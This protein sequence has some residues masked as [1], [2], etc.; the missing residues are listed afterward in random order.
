VRRGCG[1]SASA[2]TW[3]RRACGHWAG[4]R[5]LRQPPAPPKLCG[6]AA[7]DLATAGERRVVQL[8]GA[9]DPA[10]GAGEEDLFGGDQV[11][12]GEWL[13]EEREARLGGDAKH[14]ASRRPR[15]DAAVKRRCSQRAAADREQVRPAGLEDFLAIEEEGAGTVGRALDRRTVDELVG[16]ETT[17][18]REAAQ[19]DARLREND[20]RVD[21]SSSHLELERVWPRSDR[22]SQ[23]AERR[24][25][26]GAGRLRAEVRGRFGLIERPDAGRQP[27]EVVALGDRLAATHQQRVEDP[28]AGIGFVVRRH[29]GYFGHPS[30]RALLIDNHD[31]FTFNLFQLLAEVGGAEP[32]VVRNDE[33]SWAELAELD[34]DAVVISPGPGRPERRGDF[35]VC[36]EAIRRCE[37]P[38]L[39]VCL[40][41]QGIGF[42]EGG[43][44]E[45]APEPLHGRVAAIEHDDSPL[46]AGIPSPFP[47]TRYHSLALARP[48][49]AELAE[50]AS[51][52]GVPMAVAHRHRPQWGVQFHP[53]SVATPHGR[54]LLANFRDLAAASPRSS[55][56]A[57]RQSCGSLGASETTKEPHDAKRPSSGSFVVLE[58]TK[59]PR[60]DGRGAADRPELE[61]RLAV[62]RVDLLPDAEAFF[63]DLYGDRPHAFWLDSAGAG[64]AS[65]FSFMGDAS[66][67]LGAVVTYDV[68][69][70]HVTVR[71]PVSAGAV[72]P[73]SLQGNEALP[74]SF[75]E[76]VEVRDESI[77]EFVD[78]ELQ[79]LRP[80]AFPDL[81]FEF[82]C[83]FVGYLGYEL[84]A[85]CDHRAAHTSEH[86]DAALIF[87]DR[88][89]ALDHQGE[90]TY[91]LCLHGDGEEAAAAGWLDVTASRLAASAGGAEPGAGPTCNVGPAPGSAP[92]TLSI[93]RSHDQ[94]LDDVETSLDLLREG[95]S[96]EICLTN[97]LSVETD[98]DPLSLYRSLRRA[99]PAPFAAFLRLGD[100]SILS[101][102]PERFLRVSRDGA[103]EA[104][105]IKGTSGRGA[106]SAEDEALA[107]AL[108]TDPKN[109]AENLMIVDL[110]RNDLGAVCAVGSVEVPETM[111][112]E[113][114]ETVH[115]LVSSVR[116]RLR[117]GATA[118]D[119]IRSCFPPG[120]MTGAPKLRTTEILDRLEGAPRGVYSG[121]LGWLG[122][123]GAAD[124]AV[125]I[126]TLVLADGRVTAG[127]GGAIV[128][129]SDPER[130]YE[131][132]LLKAA[133][134][135]RAIDSEIDPASISLALQSVAAAAL[136]R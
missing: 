83:G 56:Q 106:T 89:I 125:T 110:L 39:G 68:D 70:R 132:M 38:L 25:S 28:A 87:A 108:A 51:C 11:R 98:P 66:G 101:S 74:R 29:R 65:R 42:A 59:E 19:G 99:N 15:Q 21:G 107:A 96:Y 75:A 105:P 136:P 103:A 69:A 12:A 2:A 54:R 130:E 118:A 81:P 55:S 109:R 40:G 47:A 26:G 86:P 9:L 46:F 88:L 79:R 94:Y 73:S 43:R 135:L 13:L 37:K 111:A 124:L 48:L 82:D 7:T 32:L 93:A 33:A 53:E 134:P 30:V 97:Q 8:L 71:R 5:G 72:A 52:D 44:V 90:A 80:A 4:G 95:E 84:K 61:L 10:D 1:S 129:G 78:R 92:P 24:A 91:L 126:R 76:P 22:Q 16:T 57:R 85:D 58:P 113:S 128:L 120:S 50:I 20:R 102:S 36:A 3:F 64:P 23:P 117:P 45:P 104:R 116:G 123:G 62:R 122:L 112:V 127:A 41:H 131:E 6:D 49:P 133:A 63:A 121:A 114:Y 18:Q 35:G 100:L 67:P 31:S 60:D 34:F 119:A 14:G 27:L 17:C 115:Q 77:F